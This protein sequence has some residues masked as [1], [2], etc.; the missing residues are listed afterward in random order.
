MLSAQ[1]LKQ[2]WQKKPLSRRGRKLP[3]P[4]LKESWA[5]LK[6]KPLKILNHWVQ[7]CRMHRNENP[8]SHWVQNFRRLQNENPREWRKLQPPTRRTERK[9]WSRI[10]TRNIQHRRKKRRIFWRK[11]RSGNLKKRP[12]PH[13]LNL[14]VQSPQSKVIGKMRKVI[15][16]QQFIFSTKMY[17]YSLYIWNST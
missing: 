7:S 13:G 17:I 1:S 11:E 2:R 8:Q 14:K 10:L 15:L 5:I 9:L 6:R 3:R 4:I 12:D 16:Y